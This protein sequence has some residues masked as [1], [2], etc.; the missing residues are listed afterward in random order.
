MN[1]NRINRGAVAEMMV[2]VELSKLGYMVS[3]PISHGATYDLIVDK[4]GSLRKVQI[5]RAYTATIGK[6]LVSKVETC[7]IVGSKPIKYKD[8]DYDV[9]VA[10]D[11]NNSRFWVL[12]YSVTKNYSRQI[13]LRTAKFERFLSDW[14]LM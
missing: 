13:E 3:F 10:V 8:G 14:S 9:M 7:R 11:V 2:A 4:G 12:P 6:T 5:K 1:H